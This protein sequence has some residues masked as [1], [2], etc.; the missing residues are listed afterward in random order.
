MILAVIFMRAIQ[1][2]RVVILAGD[3]IGGDAVAFL[4]AANFVE[5]A[6]ILFQ[7]RGVVAQGNHIPDALGRVDAACDREGA[8]RFFFAFA[9]VGI[10]V[11]FD[12]TI[13]LRIA[14][15][16]LVILAF[17]MLQRC[18]ATLDAVTHWRIAFAGDVSGRFVAAGVP[19]ILGAGRRKVNT[20]IGLRDASF[21][22]IASLGFVT[23]LAFHLV[24]AARL[25]PAIV[26]VAGRLKIF[27]R[28]FVN[29][30]G[31]CCRVNLTFVRTHDE[32]GDFCTSRAM[33]EVGMKFI[34]VTGFVVIKF[35]VSTGVDALLIRAT[36]KR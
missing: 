33:S 23:G 19:D 32:R 2:N 24:V 31:T 26:F 35:T 10:A 6:A 13:V 14:I 16:D 1:K 20:W 22:G 7:T 11:P 5:F 21:L 9:T 30:H 8:I 18:D 36:V 27:A 34:A 12:G 3:G 17:E 29:N 28:V 4:D 25:Q 15:N